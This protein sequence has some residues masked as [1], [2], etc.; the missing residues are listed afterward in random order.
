MDIDVL[1]LHL[2]WYNS[3]GDIFRL[4]RGLEPSNSGHTAG[5]RFPDVL[6]CVVGRHAVL[7]EEGYL[8]SMAVR[9]SEASV[10]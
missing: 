2:T 6:D 3:M 5:R 8:K 4:S 1:F 10:Y 7:M 9:P